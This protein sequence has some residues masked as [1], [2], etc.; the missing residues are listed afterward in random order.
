M[1]FS[2]MGFLV[3]VISVFIVIFTII[4]VVQD[5]VG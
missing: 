1:R 3:T 2:P 5:I 4:E